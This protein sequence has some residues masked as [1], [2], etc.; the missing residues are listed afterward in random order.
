M[1]FNKEITIVEYNPQYAA[2]IAK[3]WNDSHESWGGD[4]SIRTEE[5]VL[6]EH[7]NSGYLKVFLAIANDEVVGYCSFSHYKEDANALYIP[8]LNVRPDYHGFKIGKRLVLRAVEE[9]LKLGF[10]RLDLY[11]WPGNIKAV[12]AYKKSGFFWEMRDDTTHLM[13]L[14]P[15]VLQTEAVEH[16]FEKMNWYTDSIREILVCPDGREDSGFDYFTYM[17]SRDSLYLKMEYER[18]GRGLRLI[19]TDDYLIK[20][21]IPDHHQ[22]PYGA[23][24]SIVYEAINKSGKPLHLEI[25]SVTN[26]SIHFNLHEKRN[27]ELQERIE[28]TFFVHPIEEEQNAFQTHPVVE[29]RLFINGLLATFKTGIKPTFPVKLKIQIP[30]RTVFIKEVIELELTLENKYDT[31]KLF[32]F[33]LPSD[34]ILSFCEPAIQMLVPA[35]DRRTVTVKARLLSYGIWH[36][37]IG[38]YNADKT[39]NSVILFQNTSLV[40]PGIHAV[41]GGETDQEWLISNGQYSLRLNKTSN[42]ASVYEGTSNEVRFH[43][44]K[45]GLPYT[46]EYQKNRAIRVSF[47][48]EEAMIMEAEYD[49]ASISLSI[50]TVIML[51]SN[52]IISRHHVIQNQGSSTFAE[53]LFLKEIFEFGLED[54][55]VPYKSKFLDLRKGPDASDFDYWDVR[56]ITENWI[57]ADDGKSTRGIT[58]PHEQELILEDSNYGI[59]HSLNGVPERGSVQTEPIRVALGTWKHW[60]DFRSYALGTESSQVLDTI[61]QL[62]TNINQGNPFVKKALELEIIEHKSTFLD[63]EISISSAMGSIESN[64]FPVCSEQN[65]TKMEFSLPLK[66][67]SKADILSIRLDM[68]PYEEERFRLVFPLSE[69]TV[70]TW[71]DQMENRE[72]LTVDNGVL[73]IQASSDFAPSLFSLKHLGVEWLS[74]SFPQPGPKSWWNPWIGGISAEVDGMS[75]SSLIEEK[76]EA[77]FAEIIDNMGNHWTGIRMSTMILK[78]E[79]FKGLTLDQYFVMLPGVPVL[80]TAIQVTQN[81]GDSLYPLKIGNTTFYKASNELSDTRVYVTNRFGD[82]MIYKAGKVGSEIISASGIIQYGSQERNHRLIMIAHPKV[83]SCES[84]VNNQVVLST[85]SE[86]IFVKDGEKGYGK[87]QFYVISD[88]LAPEEAYQDLLHIRFDQYS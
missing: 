7:R 69:Q 87:P 85:V 57:F 36:H 73:Q 16:Y 49:L 67:T 79:L 52:G 63:G 34:S 12:P 39:D 42:V 74:S 71:T 84:Y 48:H 25:Q 3:M 41:F 66:S 88:L 27:V 64:R 45:C 65:R 40:F 32:D 78:N 31:D 59:Q 55:I 28:G 51:Y 60:R 19:E 2:S 80:A 43:F 11:T 35:K 17:W 18:T 53:S 29:A 1:K 72:I 20:A 9:T 26:S 46:N 24:Y 86:K 37:R 15:S 5:S 38:I 54:T 10:P 83:D 81:T 68:E 23:N 56:K 61:R 58:W 30:N 33:E 47:R 6:N 82:N 62:E 8:L 70:S 77:S 4:N 76:R 50:T 21:T 22:L 75:E 44:P 14:I 13:N